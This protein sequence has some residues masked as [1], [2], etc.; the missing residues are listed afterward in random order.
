MCAERFTAK[1]RHTGE[2]FSDEGNVGMLVS[3]GDKVYARFFI[4]VL[5][6]KEILLTLA[7]HPRGIFKL[8]RHYLLHEPLT[9]EV[10][11]KDG[12]LIAVEIPKIIS[13]ILHAQQWYCVEWSSMEGFYLDGTRVC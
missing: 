8:I 1:L 11:Q 9:I 4:R 7:R 3:H 5:T 6:M 12:S 2:N 13:R 10:K